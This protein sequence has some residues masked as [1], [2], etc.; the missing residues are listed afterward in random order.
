MTASGKRAFT[1]GAG[2]SGLPDGGSVSGALQGAQP[3]C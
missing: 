2:G 1:Q 3:A